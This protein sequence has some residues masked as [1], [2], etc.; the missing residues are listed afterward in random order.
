MAGY[1][2]RVWGGDEEELREISG[3]FDPDGVFQRLQPGYF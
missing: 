3:R 1:F 2:W